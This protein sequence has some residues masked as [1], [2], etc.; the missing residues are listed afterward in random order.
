LKGVFAPSGST[1]P[2][3]GDVLKQAKIRGVES[4]GMLCSEAELGLSEEHDGI[5]ELPA[6]AKTGG[7][8]AAAL[9]LE[10]P[11]IEVALTPNRG[12]CAAV[13]GIAR[14]L[15]A[16]GLGR[17]K[18]LDLA[19]VPGLY[20]SPVKVTIED[21]GC[22]LFIGRHIRGVKNGPSPK[23]LQDRLKAVGLRPISALV[24]I[25]NYFTLTYARPLHVYD[26][27]SLAGDIVVRRAKPGES[28]EAL[29]DK[30]YALD[31]DMLAICDGDGVLGL[32][33]VIG[34]TP[35]GC[36]GETVN[37]YLETALFDPLAIARTGRR[38]MIDS[39][40][41]YRFE[42]GVDPEFAFPGM[43]LATRMILELCGGEA[44]KPVSAGDVP[45]TERTYVLRPTRVAR[46][47]GVDVPHDAQLG[48]LQTLGFAV[49]DRE[50]GLHVSPPSWRPDIH[51]EAD[52][53]EEILRIHGF[54]KI[55]PVMP[56]RPF[57]VTKEAVTPRHKRA[58]LARRVLAA[59]G[60]DE[61]VTW[62]FTDEKTAALFGGGAAELRLKNP[63]SADLSVM[64]SSLLCGLV[65]AAARNG[66]RGFPDIA[67]FETAP[68]YRDAS[69]AGQDS[70]AAGVRAGLAVPR[71]HAAESRPADALDARA[72]ALAVLSALGAPVENLQVSRDAPDWYHPGRSGTLRLGKTLLARFGAL[73]PKVLAECGLKT[74]CVA[75]E[76]FLDAVPEAKKK[77]TAKPLARLSAFQPVTRDFAFLVAEEIAAEQVLRAAR[78]AEKT[79]I[80]GVSLFDVYRGKGVPEG[81]KS[82]AIAVTL[83]PRE[84][85]LTDAEIEEIAGRI[86][87]QVAK[88]TGGVLRG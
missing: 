48:I 58:S 14:D 24:D 74:E 30:T 61:A 18:T 37:V 33:G 80:E 28:L 44:S 76:V 2:A 84:R 23:W 63:I 17:L 49:E 1:I 47:T 70:I 85:T 65:P 56:E 32:G 42:R 41:R 53:V 26:A 39:D 5:I 67:L 11:M 21:A 72:D 68:C 54:D 66:D 12:D 19:P 38:L 20:D 75:F 35:S 13:R 40:A 16:A 71:H 29:D 62:S 79:L 27:E 25:T 52:L 45:A 8:A 59:R 64:R 46:L 34:G 82:L 77:G 86:V 6:D 57:A 60:M 83:Q 15:A 3:S 87:A 9:G 43:E 4:F 73:H 31:G 50:D 10:D 69:A 55:E 88:A 81:S 78:S 36:T 22:P 7:S 51:G